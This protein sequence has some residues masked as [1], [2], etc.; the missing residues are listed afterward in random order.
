MMASVF[1]IFGSLLT[2]VLYR[3]LDPRMRDER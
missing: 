2:D 1:V 3:W